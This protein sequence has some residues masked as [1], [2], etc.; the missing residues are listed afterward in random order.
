MKKASTTKVS[1]K[2]Q[3]P[4]SFLITSNPETSD[5]ASSINS[6]HT[7]LMKIMIATIIKEQR[8]TSAKAVVVSNCV[9]S[10]ILPIQDAGLTPPQ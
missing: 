10:K 6:L 5:F 3:E 8:N 7:F 2:N 4:D 1:S 9:R